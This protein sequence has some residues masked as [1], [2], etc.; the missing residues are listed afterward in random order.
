[1]I[2][3]FITALREAGVDPDWRDVAD[4]LWLADIRARAVTRDRR[5]RTPAGEPEAE[6]PLSPASEAPEPAADSGRPPAGSHE[7]PRADDE[8]AAAGGTAPSM[9]G[10][11][12]GWHL[13]ERAGP[14]EAAAAGLDT[15]VPARYALPGGQE[16]G[17]ALRPLKQHR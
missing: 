10:M 1:M 13:A 7:E 8:P 3:R 17:R 11:P 14:D 5:D 12:A 2:D 9:P 4:V 16:I 6:Q 15:V